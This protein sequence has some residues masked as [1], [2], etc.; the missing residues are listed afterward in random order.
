M[1]FVTGDKVLLHG[2]EWTVI[3]MDDRAIVLEESNS[4]MVPPVRKVCP[5][6]ESFINKW[7]LTGVTSESCIEH[8]PLELFG[9]ADY[10]LPNGAQVTIRYGNNGVEIRLDGKRTTVRK[11]YNVL[12][13][14]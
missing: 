11:L 6:S 14:T 8:T 1:L 3:D 9:E 10:E 4:K 13:T 7:L 2:R 5:A 12:C